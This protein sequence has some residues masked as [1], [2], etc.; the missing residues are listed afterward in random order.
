MLAIQLED[1]RIY[2]A[3]CHI[4]YHTASPIKKSLTTGHAHSLTPLWMQSKPIHLRHRLINLSPSGLLG[5]PQVLVGI[6]A[7]VPPGPDFL[8]D[9]LVVGAV[10]A[11][12]ARHLGAGRIA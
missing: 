11:L 6:G 9:G 12:G 3:I 7:L 4:R 1:V 2:T 10:E 8:A 5:G